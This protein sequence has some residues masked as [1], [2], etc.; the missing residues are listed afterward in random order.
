MDSIALMCRSLEEVSI[1]GCLRDEFFD[2]DRK[3]FSRFGP[4]LSMLVVDGCRIQIHPDRRDRSGGVADELMKR[5]SGR[6]GRLRGLH[7]MEIQSDNVD[8]YGLRSV[9]EEVQA[10]EDLDSTEGDDNEPRR[11]EMPVN[12]RIWRGLQKAADEAGV[13]MGFGWGPVV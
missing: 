7:V 5:A 11:V 6:G 13:C 4:N 2:P 9:Q 12:Y 3:L 1:P 10:G 8:W